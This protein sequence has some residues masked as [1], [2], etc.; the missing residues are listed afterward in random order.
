MGIFKR[1]R[2]YGCS[3]QKNQSSSTDSYEKELAVIQTKISKYQRRSLS[4]AMRM[5]STKGLLTLYSTII[6]LVVLVSVVLKVI[7]ATAAH[8]SGV[9]LAP[10][11]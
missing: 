1:V 5:R 3:W 7:P 4:L 2:I 8:V 11:L 6:W 9:V 10:F